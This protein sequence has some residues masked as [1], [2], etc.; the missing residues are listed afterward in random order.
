MKGCVSSLLAGLMI[1]MFLGVKNEED[2]DRCCYEAK[3]MKKNLMHRMDEW[4]K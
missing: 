2:I 1:G 3:R 4:I